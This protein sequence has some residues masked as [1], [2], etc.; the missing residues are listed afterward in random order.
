MCPADAIPDSYDIYVS[1]LNIGDGLHAS[2]LTLWEAITF[3]IDGRE[4]DLTTGH[5]QD[6]R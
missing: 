1:E 2:D 5:T 3:T 4:I 6:Q